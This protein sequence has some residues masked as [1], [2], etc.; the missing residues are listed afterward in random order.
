MVGRETSSW[1]ELYRRVVQTDLCAGCG[2]C[3][4]ACPRKVL[5]YDPAS[6]HPVSVQVKK[7]RIHAWIHLPGV[8]AAGFITPLPLPG[9]AWGPARGA[10]GAGGGAGDGGARRSAA[11]RLI[12]GLTARDGN[13][14]NRA[15]CERRIGAQPC[16]S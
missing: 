7:D 5:D 3:V 14:R 13:R 4:M 10:D 15:R 6:Y 11:P 8:T 2:A 16:A 9:D 1:Q 12:L